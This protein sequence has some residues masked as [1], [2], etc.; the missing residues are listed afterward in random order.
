MQQNNLQA[1]SN[2]LGKESLFDSKIAGGGSDVVIGVLASA[3]WDMLKYVGEKL[4]SIKGDIPEIV[5]F[6]SY[7]ARD[8]L[9][10]SLKAGKEYSDL[11][12][13]A[14][15]N[16]DPE[17]ERIYRKQLSNIY[18]QISTV[19]A[20]D[21]YNIASRELRAGNYARGLSQAF[22]DVSR[23]VT[24]RDLPL[25]NI[26]INDL[27]RSDSNSG[28]IN[29]LA[30]AAEGTNQNLSEAL[31][32]LDKVKQG[33]LSS[34][35]SSNFSSNPDIDTGLK[36]LSQIKEDQHVDKQAVPASIVDKEPTAN[37]KSRDSGIGGL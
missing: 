11:A 19:F 28:Q 14:Q 22:L 25:P 27:R 24:E 32:I 30:N 8:T 3:I 33:S 36:I 20:N 13:Q 12:R 5:N 18:E 4:I 31:S 16:K 15:K 35:T 29:L 34:L 23:K 2:S 21:A 6:M 10:S 17:M 9:E 1:G 7:G 37:N 26:H